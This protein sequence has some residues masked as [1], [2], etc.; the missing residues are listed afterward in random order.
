VGAVAAVLPISVVFYWLA[1]LLGDAVD[2]TQDFHSLKYS[3]LGVA[4][5][6]ICPCLFV[7]CGTATA[8]RAKLLVALLLGLV[9]LQFAI[10]AYPI[11]DV[12]GIAII[13]SGVIAGWLL[14]AWGYVLRRRAGLPA[15]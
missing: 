8:P 12:Y 5:F 11:P 2:R 14:I 13:G 1:I 4:V 7:W 15:R 9:P 6:V 3:V 10:D